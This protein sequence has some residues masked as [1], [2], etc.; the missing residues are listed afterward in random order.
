M[1]ERADAARNRAAILAAAERLLA[2]NARI[3]VDHVAREAGLAKATVFHRFGSRSG[4]LWALIEERV[5]ALDAAIESGPP[6]L[7]PGAPAPDRLVAF[8]DAV[9]GMATQNVALMAGGAAPDGERQ[10]GPA[11][12]SWH[13]HVSRLI[14]ECRP[15]LDSDLLAHMLLGAL[16]TEPVGQLLRSGDTGRLTELLHD[17]LHRLLRK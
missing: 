3:S 16:H 9:V 6:P 17:L 12:Q 5:R 13:R 10:A 4:L 11:Y 15:E 7:G 2:R 1:A 14:A 8:F